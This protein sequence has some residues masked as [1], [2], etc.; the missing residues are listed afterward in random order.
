VTVSKQRPDYRIIAFLNGYEIWQKS[1][2]LT[3]EEKKPSPQEQ[4]ARKSENFSYEL[5]SMGQSPILQAILKQSG[6]DKGK[7]NVDA[8]IRLFI[9]KST[10]HISDLIKLALVESEFVDPLIPPYEFGDMGDPLI[11]ELC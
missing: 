2:K 9:E 6:F 8:L 11:D 4:F 5:S 10:P 7:G 1:E 3:I